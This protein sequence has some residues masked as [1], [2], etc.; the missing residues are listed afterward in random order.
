[1]VRAKA[2][3]SLFVFLILSSIFSYS[4]CSPDTSTL[5]PGPQHHAKTLFIGSLIS[6]GTIG[7]CCAIVDHYYDLPFTWIASYFARHILVNAVRLDLNEPENSSVVD[8]AH[9]LAAI[10]SWIAWFATDI[11]LRAGR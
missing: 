11:Y 3:R 9:S 8:T 4:A 6:G 10:A 5:Y 1:M 7:S 2:L